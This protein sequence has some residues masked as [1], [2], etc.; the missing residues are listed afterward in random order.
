MSSGVVGDG[1]LK[2]VMER[3][4]DVDPSLMLNRWLVISVFHLLG[5][6]GYTPGSA[7]GCE[8]ICSCIPSL[9]RVVLV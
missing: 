8:K 6:F 1:T 5:E 4:W 7:S 2:A 3:R 9:S